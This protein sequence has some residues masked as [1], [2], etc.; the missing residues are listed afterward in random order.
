[1]PAYK[2]IAFIVMS[3]MSSA[4]LHTAAEAYWKKF[5]EDVKVVEANQKYALALDSFAQLKR[6]QKK[7]DYQQS[8]EIQNNIINY[9]TYLTNEEDETTES[10]EYTPVKKS[11]HSKKF[12]PPARLLEK[13]QQFVTVPA[14]LPENKS[15][16]QGFVTVPLSWSDIVSGKSHWHLKIQAAV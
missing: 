10:E 7:L 15:I 5:K 13:Q 16:Q 14:K 11:R 4:S 9:I 3:L 1:M 12:H 8:L 2:N 6:Y